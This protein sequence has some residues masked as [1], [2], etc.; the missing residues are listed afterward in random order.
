MPVLKHAKKKLRQDK[1]RTIRN[2]KQ[3]EQYKDL[4]KAAKKQPNEKTVSAAFKGVD[5]AAKNNIMHE[6]K[7]ARL[8]SSLSKLLPGGKKVSATEKI[9]KKDA[10]KSAA[11]KETSSKTATIN[12]KPPAKK[13]VKTSKK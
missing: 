6:N 2:K 10:S 1:V 9:E 7:A 5:K 13:P 8:K 3:K 4:I 12:K 11:K